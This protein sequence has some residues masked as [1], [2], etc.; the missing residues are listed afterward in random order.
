M[1]DTSTPLIRHL[2]QRL[3]A[4]LGLLSV[5]AVVIMAL[6]ARAEAAELSNIPDDN[7]QVDGR[8]SDV[9]L[10]GNTIYLAGTFH[11]VNGATR[12]RLAA[13]DAD[14]GQLTSWAPRA[15][16]WVMT[17]AASE[18]GSKVYAG[19]RFTTVN[20]LTR[21]RLVAL[22]AATG[23]VDPQ[24]SPGA[25]DDVRALAVSNNSVYAGGAFTTIDAQSR[26]RLAAI[27]IST[28]TLVS[29]WSPTANNVVRTLH[30][31][32][33]ETRLYVGGYFNNISGQTRRGLAALDPTTGGLSVWNPNPGR[34]VIDLA[35]S[36]TSVFTAEG[37]GGGGETA[38]YS[39][40]TGGELWSLHADGDAQTVTVLDDKV[41]FGGHFLQLGEQ[42][43]RCFAAVDVITGALDPNWR[44][45]GG[46]GGVWALEAD[47]LRTR[48]YSGGDFTSANGQ[49]EERFAQFSE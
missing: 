25:D 36:S 47:P 22:D 16:K 2:R 20:G 18:D 32:A 42:T 19:G 45:S 48:V 14:T 8:I 31:S 46:G 4:V 49:P 21:N 10:V 29:G 44:P 37:G 3:C 5:A 43:R 34:P 17:L 13:I 38:G 6:P 15:N 11:N 28:G 41:Y 24:W 1:T 9:L 27:T 33:G 40:A 12:M 30:L 35:L 26:T 39:A 23:V 7:V